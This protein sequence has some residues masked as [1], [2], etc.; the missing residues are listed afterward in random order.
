MENSGT[1][2]VLLWPEQATMSPPTITD[3]VIDH[4]NPYFLERSPEI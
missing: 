2:I 4:L 1:A 3:A